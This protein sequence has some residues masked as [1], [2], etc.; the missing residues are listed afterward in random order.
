MPFPSGSRLG[1]YEVVTL[2]GVGGMGEV[3]RA[4]DTRLDRTV[5]IKI[6]SPQV[7]A[8]P[9]FAER[10]DVEARAISAVEHPHICALYDVGRERVQLPAADKARAP[11]DAESVA[12][13]VMQY[14]DGETLADATRRGPMSVA[15]A[16]PIAQ[17]IAEGLEA[18]H[19]HGIVHRDL[20]PSNIKLGADGQVKILDFGL[21]KIVTAAAAGADRALSPTFMT[22][23]TQLGVVLG[24]AAYMSPE[25]ARGKAVDKRTDIWAFGC[26]LFEM[27]TGRQAFDGETVTDVLAAVVGREPDWAALPADA[28]PHVR[29]VLKRCLEKDPARRLRDIGDAR[30]EL[31]PPEPSGIDELAA[32]APGAAR[33]WTTIA[34]WGI[35]AAALL[36][37]AAV[38]LVPRL[39]P[40]E[41]RP[42]MRFSAVTNFAGVEAQPSFSPDGRSIAFVSNRDGPWDVYVGLVTGG[43]LIRITNDPNLE[44]RPRWS[45]DGARLLFSRLNDQGLH[46]VWV[47]PALGG[48]ARRIVL[49][50]LNATWS[51]DGRSIAYSADG[52]LWICDATGANA[53]AVTKPDPPR[54]HHQPAFSHD[55]RSLAFLRRRDGPYGELGVADIASGTVTMLTSDGALA[56]SPVWSADDRFIYFTSSRGGTLTVWK[57][58]AA[59]GEPEQITAGQG[60]DTD[61][62]LSTDG[63]RLV[64]SSYRANINLAEMSLDPAQGAG[65]RRWLTTDSARGESS[66]RYSP[67][68]RRIAFF[69]NRAGAERETVWVM[70]ADGGNASRVVENDRVNI[71]PRWSGDSQSLIYNARQPETVTVHELYQVPLAGGAPRALS[72]RAWAPIWGD[73]AHDGRLLYRSSADTVEVYDPRTQTTRT[74]AGIRG[75]SFWSRDGRHIGHLVRPGTGKPAD[76]GVWV[77]RSDEAQQRIFPGW[78]VWF[79]WTAAGDV[80]ALEG[81]PDVKGV[82]W[83]IDA[84][85]QRTRVL[86]DVPLMI[87]PTGVYMTPSARFDVHPDGRRIV[88]EALEMLESDIGMIENVR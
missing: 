56:M 60:E 44:I 86:N 24:T 54:G 45:P 35:A 3:Y 85:G 52:V 61:I 53:R 32:P 11:A 64:F 17:Q 62:D 39:R 59:G 15:E 82:L 27:L 22:A 19:E 1:P 47:A 83:R 87:S 26:V 12:F 75:E 14:V 63:A 70:D 21:A 68:G 71:F 2:I 34:P 73:V 10:F 66:P 13:L 37:L 16:L 20:K 55:G 80:L 84:D 6:L 41:R 25:Q 8:I 28:P 50:G 36:A 7:A 46:D 69:S 30:L 33:G 76:A 38:V 74:V 42:P 23:P 5:A 51:F 79:T 4:R 77:V 65:R 31:D 43:S 72:I 49:N 67:D 40:A 88:I 48:A 57:L 78:V 81:R 29:R 9:G 18:A 58:P